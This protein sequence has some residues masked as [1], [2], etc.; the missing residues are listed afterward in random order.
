MQKC[1]LTSILNY[2]FKQILYIKGIFDKKI[3]A[4]NGQHTLQKN[5]TFK[6]YLFI[7]IIMFF[8]LVL[9]KLKTSTY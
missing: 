7:P 8:T 2:L 9:L 4:Q 1:F 5:C 3:F 6:E